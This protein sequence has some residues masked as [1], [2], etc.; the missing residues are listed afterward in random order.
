MLKKIG[1]FFD[2]SINSFAVLASVLLIFLWGLI[3]VTVIARMPLFNYSIL[4]SIDFVELGLV[5]VAFLGAA[6]VLG[7]EGH[8]RVDILVSRLKPRVRIIFSIINSITGL[9]ICLILSW[10]GFKVVINHYQM[11]LINYEAMLKMLT[12]PQYA[13]IA[14]GS[15]L[16]VFQF[17]KRLYR[18]LMLWNTPVVE[19]KA[20]KGEAVE[21]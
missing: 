2:I 6:W 10:Y 21:Y 5:G 7:K 11:G 17:A 15:L 12:W 18:N 8:V 16:L 4:W 20:P 3:L 9:V 14:V 13:I 19:D 1:W